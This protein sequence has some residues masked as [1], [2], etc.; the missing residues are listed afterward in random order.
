MH[1]NL[2][3][4]EGSERWRGEGWGKEGREG[5][6]RGKKARREEG[7]DRAGGREKQRGDSGRNGERQRGGAGERR[8]IKV[9]ARERREF[10]E[11]QN[12]SL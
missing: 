7:G 9:I 12:P 11:K 4:E 8:E 10:G 6:W 5:A 3:M 2:K 1:A